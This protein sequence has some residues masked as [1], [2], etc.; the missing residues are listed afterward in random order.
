MTIFEFWLAHPWHS[1]GAMLLIAVT[2]MT[3][4]DALGRR[5]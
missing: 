3:V 2:T 4:A 1:W 5:K